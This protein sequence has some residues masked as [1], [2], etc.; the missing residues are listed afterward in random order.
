[1]VSGGLLNLLLSINLLTA[2]SQRNESTFR[3]FEAIRGV[4]IP[5]KVSLG[6]FAPSSMDLTGNTT[7]NNDDSKHNMTEKILENLS[8]SFREHFSRK[9]GGKSVEGLLREWNAIELCKNKWTNFSEIGIFEN[10]DFKMY[11]PR[12]L[13]KVNPHKFEEIVHSDFLEI[14]KKLCFFYTDGWFYSNG[15]LLDC[16]KQYPLL[17]KRYRKDLNI[18]ISGQLQMSVKLRIFNDELFSN[19]C[20]FNSAFS[21][22]FTIGISMMTYI[23]PRL[24]NNPL[25]R[26]LI[27]SRGP[28]KYLYKLLGASSEQII[29]VED[30]TMYY[31]PKAE[32]I[33]RY[34][35]FNIMQVD[36]FRFMK[37]THF[38][39]IQITLFVPNTIWKGSLAS[40]CNG[41][42]KTKTCRCISRQ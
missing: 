29:P 5:P 26:V 24:L 12:H 20:P 10:D 25:A 30:H 11:P 16:Q 18:E 8:S 21:H 3:A 23:L 17:V 37:I 22:S 27:P 41:E 33:L 40:K 42:N 32:L 14:P 39:N 9:C 2:I 35:P 19:L 7:T 36:C 6:R 34:P 28:I 4:T 31:S 1:M 13:N 15:L 38:E